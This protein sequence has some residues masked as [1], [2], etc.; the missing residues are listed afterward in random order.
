MRSSIF[1]NRVEE[2][3]DVGGVLNLSVIP[4]KYR[5]SEN[6]LKMNWKLYL[7]RTPPP[8]PFPSRGAQPWRAIIPHIIIRRIIEMKVQITKDRPPCSVENRHEEQNVDLFPAEPLVTEL[9]HH[10]TI[11]IDKVNTEDC[12]REAEAATVDHDEDE[13]MLTVKIRIFKVSEHNERR[14]VRV[15]HLEYIFNV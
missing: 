8:P 10:C 15:N 5:F 12:Q 3:N 11:T 1:I 6:V 2:D 9:F 7:P 14:F 13:A 4:V